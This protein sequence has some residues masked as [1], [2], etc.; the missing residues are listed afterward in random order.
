LHAIRLLRTF[1]DACGERR[2]R[3][4]RLRREG[5]WRP[6]LGR[7]PTIGR[8]ADLYYIRCIRT[9]IASICGGHLAL[10]SVI[11]SAHEP[12]SFTHTCRP[13]D[14]WLAVPAAS[15]LLR[16]GG[17]P[18]STLTSDGL[19]FVTATASRRQPSGLLPTLGA[20][21]SAR[22]PMPSGVRPPRAPAHGGAPPRPAR[23][24]TCPVVSPCS[25]AHARSGCTESAHEPG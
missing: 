17:Y 19:R 8:L 2:R 3:D 10:T 22:Q 11:E 14:A 18:G 1:D 25:R 21:E 9:S 7:D 24:W 12:A 20:V 15:A 23:R 16:N 5:P 4:R 13:H 6:R